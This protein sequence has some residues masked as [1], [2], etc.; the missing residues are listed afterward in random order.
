MRNMLLWGKTLLVCKMNVSLN[1]RDSLARNCCCHS[2]VMMWLIVSM[3]GIVMSELAHMVAWVVMVKV[4]SRR[5]RLY[6]CTTVLGSQCESS[7]WWSAKKC[8][9]PKVSMW[10]TIMA[11][12]SE[13]KPWTNWWSVTLHL[14]I[15]LKQ[16]PKMWKCFGNC[17]SGFKFDQ[18]LG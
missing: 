14:H 10:L 7:S 18:T 3:H 13:N 15:C 1:I 2:D 11:V 16:Q 12:F 5:E 6:W 4:M 9:H 8:T 17:L